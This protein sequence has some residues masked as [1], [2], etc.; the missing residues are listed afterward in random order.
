MTSE[1]SMRRA[2]L[3]AFFLF[4][5]VHAAPAD[6]PSHPLRPL[7]NVLL[8]ADDAAVQRDVLQGMI[9]ALQGRRL[10][11][12]D[13]WARVKEKLGA[14]ANAEVREKALLLSVMF[15]DPDATAAL[16]KTAA[17]PKAHEA[18]RQTALRTLVEAKAPDLPPLL[19]GLLSDPAMRGPALRALGSF[20][21]PDTPAAVL[22]HY[23]DFTEAEKSDAVATLASRP[24]YAQALLDAMERGDVPTRDLSAFTARQLL[25][26][27]DKALADRL[28]KVWGVIRPAGGDKTKLLAHYLALTPPDALKKADRSRGRAVFARTCAKCHTLFGEGGKIGPDLTGSQR[29]NPEYVLTKVLDPSAVVA[30]DYQMTVFTLGDGRVVNGIAKAEDGKVVTVQTQND[31]LRLDKADIE[32]R[33]A[34]AMSMMPDGQL[35]MLSDA[36]V[37]DLIAYLAGPDQPPLPAD[38]PKP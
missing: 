7:I 31:V 15:G 28:T 1:D 14:S 23:K 12:P 18:G 30:K 2:A 25:T 16:R 9:D 26:F 19:R 5:F 38:G 29:V 24:A 20:S 4:L 27:N 33:K 11:P 37:R 36:E 3:P 17:D 32:S 22:S 13:G 6:A 10:P 34:S 35:A 8:T 21:D